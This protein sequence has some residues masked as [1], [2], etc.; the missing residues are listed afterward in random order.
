MAF[1]NALKLLVSKFGLVWMLLLYITVF[2]VLLVSLSLPFALPLINLL[3]SS[4]IIERVNILFNSIVNGQP[5]DVWFDHIYEIMLSF[6]ELLA[7]NGF[8][9]FNTAMLLFLIL[10][11][12][13]RFFLGLYEIPLTCV[14]EGVMS[15]GAR[16]G[17]M[18]CFIASLGKSCKYNLVKMLYTLV[19]DILIFAAI[20]Q[21][22]E[23]FGI[24]VIRMFAPFIIMLVFILLSAVRYTLI[25]MWAPSIVVGK[26][27]IFSGFAFSA[28]RSFKFLGS[29]FSTFFLTWT[30]IITFN[31][32]FGLFT[33]G[34]G[35]IATIPISMLFIAIVNMTI[36]YGK[37]NRRYYVD[38]TVITPPETF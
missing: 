29:V 23:L 5:I 4:G 33:F 37:N 3:K 28:K 21:L 12:C 7:T 8:A 2:A 14:L 27:K 26:E 24:A 18:S 16:M 20:F 30:L 17:F 32:V 35:L 15:S 31:I 22:F 9:A 10:G 1:K 25:S 19:F 34:A 11:V 13:Y 6:K 36:Y 38:S